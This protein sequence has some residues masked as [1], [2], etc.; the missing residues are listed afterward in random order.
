[1]LPLTPQERE[2]MV[3]LPR[4]WG[5]LWRARHQGSRPPHKMTM[6]RHSHFLPRRFLGLWSW[7]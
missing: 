5:V 7:D 1:M 2:P 4:G 6:G 3:P